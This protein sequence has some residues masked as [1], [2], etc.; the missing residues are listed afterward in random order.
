MF[1][2]ILKNTFLLFNLLFAFFLLL[3]I[4][5]YYISPEKIWILPFFGFLYPVL[6]LINIIYI[7]FWGVQR[8]NWFWI[9]FSLI[10]LSWGQLHAYYQLP[11]FKAKKANKGNQISLITYNVRAFNQYNWAKNIS[12]R[13]QMLNFL[14]G[15]NTDVICLQEVFT[16][17]KNKL[18]TTK[19]LIRQFVN[20]H[21]FYIHF[22]ARN[23]KSN[24]GIAIFTKFPI[25]N[26]GFINYKNTNN[27]TIFVDMKVNED[28]IRF[29]NNHLQSIHIGKSQYEM[30]DTL[31]M[32]YN[33]KEISQ[34]KNIFSQFILASRKRAAQVDILAKHIQCCPYKIIVCGDFNDTPYSYTYHKIRHNLNDVFIES[35][36]GIGNTYFG[37]LPSF[38]IDY[39]FHSKTISSYNLK[40]FKIPFSDHFPM[41]CG[42]TWKK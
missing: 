15:K 27:V 20:H 14:V 38:R 17:N 24:Y 31:S 22:T 32:N 9:S 7:I 42:F 5:A 2:K 39:V 21:H 6:L 3:S 35:G 11:L 33:D 12:A 23:K 16:S 4:G 28:T 10:I 36:S 34:L 41:Q 18:L 19:N 30:L 37:M 40:I 1:Q 29:Y 26:K 25:V 8:K 13:D